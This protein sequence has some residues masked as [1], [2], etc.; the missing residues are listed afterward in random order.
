MGQKR[1]TAE[2]IIGTL[3]KW[4]WS[5]PRDCGSRRFVKAWDYRADLLPLAQ[6]LWGVH[7]WVIISFTRHKIM[8]VFYRYDRVGRPLPS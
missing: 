6:G 7:G 8:P 2:E 1:Y 5:Y 3:R 4:G